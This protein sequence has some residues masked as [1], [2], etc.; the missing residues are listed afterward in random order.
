MNRPIIGPLNNTTVDQ[1]TDAYDT[2][3]WLPKNVPETN[4][5]VGITGSLLSSAS[6]SLVATDRS[7]PGPEGL[8]AAEPDGRRLDGR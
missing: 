2:I 7:A 1:S 4:G 3:D 6:R 8:R 5:K